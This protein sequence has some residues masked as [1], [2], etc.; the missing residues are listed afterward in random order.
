MNSG[1][2]CGREDVTNLSCPVDAEE[3]YPRCNE[4]VSE[5]ILK[6]LQ[7]L[8]LSKNLALTYWKRCP[9]ISNNIERR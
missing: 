1:W 5:I 3:I 7:G 2:K 9:S 4:T 6:W 8:A